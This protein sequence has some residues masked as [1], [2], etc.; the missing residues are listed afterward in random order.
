MSLLPP[1]KA[2]ILLIAEPLRP[3]GMAGYAEDLLTGL[4]ALGVSPRMI[5]PEAPSEGSFETGDE[6]QLQVFPGLLNLWYRPFLKNK[7]VRWTRPW[8]PSLVHG[9]SAFTAK[10]CQQLAQILKIPYVLSVQH[11]QLKGALKP[12]AQCKRILAC[13]EAIRENLVNDARVAKEL[14]K[15]V[16][17][18]V[19][20][21]AERD[22]GLRPFPDTSTEPRR[23]LVSTFGPLTPNQDTA[24]FLRAA[25]IVEQRM[26][27]EAWF[28]V[29]GEGPEDAALFALARQLGLDKQLVFAH[30]GVSR[31]RILKDTDVYV[32]AARQEGLGYAMLEAMSW[33][34]PV[35]ASSVG[36]LIPLVREG[37]TGF[38]TPPGNPEAL[39][40]KI[41]LLLKQPELR[42][43]MGQAGRKLALEKHS[44]QRMIER[45]VEV[46]A[47]ALGYNVSKS[48]SSMPVLS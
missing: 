14:I 6:D 11:F 38:L 1:E 29:V 21:P 30:A 12:D 47:A 16:A 40:E 17:L 42:L 33:A 3:G 46:Y 27:H 41:L 18:G 36:G 9:L 28:T 31:D 23:M 37:E 13:G 44:R 8:Q 48:T 22:L 15:V 19:Q 5:T 2:S 43:R 32:Q 10:T 26:P 45:T 25:K 7:I 24:T 4:P 35:V 34:R 20:A 39:A